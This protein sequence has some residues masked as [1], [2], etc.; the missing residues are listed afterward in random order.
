LSQIKNEDIKID[1]QT[2]IINMPPPQILVVD[3]NN[4]MTRVYD[5]KQGIL[6]KGDDE[7]ES[8]ARLA[9]EQEIQTA[10]CQSGILNQATENGRKQLTILFKGLGYQ[11]VILNIPNASC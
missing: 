7:L 11:T 2:L 5:R 3:L 10:A 6:T 4:D 8:E 1:R 9:A